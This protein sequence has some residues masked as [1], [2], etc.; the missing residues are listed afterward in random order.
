M[1]KSGDTDGA[2]NKELFAGN[3]WEAKP[4][5]ASDI[6]PAQPDE[7]FDWSSWQAKLPALANH[8]QAKL[9]VL[10]TYI[11]NYI[12]ILCTGKPG[13]DRFRLTLVDGFAGG[14]I[15]EGQKFG[16]PFVL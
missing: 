5:S 12:Q 13:Q 1:T 7:L 8:S 4:P 11:E 16:S 2:P 3:S 15:Y 10:R 14:G 9:N 6:N